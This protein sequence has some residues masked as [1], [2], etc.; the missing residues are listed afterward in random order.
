MLMPSLTCL[1][2]LMLQSSPVAK[3]PWSPDVRCKLNPAKPQ[4]LHPDAFSL[5]R[6]NAVAHR[7]TQGLNHAVSRGNVHDTDITIN[8]N[9]YTGA[10]DISVR[11]LSAAQIQALLGRL[12]E[13]GFA[14]WYRKDGEDGWTGPPHIHSVW[15]GTRLKPV[16]RQQ[17]ESWLDGRNG[18][19]FNQPYHF[20]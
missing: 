6:E 3:S 17:V 19:G 18:L 16:L 14:A 12:A 2:C 5:L 15:A 8:G 10:A 9:A 13:L 7:I 4:G 1:L 11:C 20:W